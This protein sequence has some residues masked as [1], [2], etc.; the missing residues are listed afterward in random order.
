MSQET[1]VWGPA[2]NEYRFGDS[3][4]DVN[5]NLP[6]SFGTVEWN[7]L[8]VA[9]EYKENEVRYFC[10]PLHDFPDPT[11]FVPPNTYV[12]SS[13]YA[14]FLFTN[15]KL[16][17]TSIRLIHDDQARNYKNVT[18][19]YAHAVN[20]PV[21]SDGTFH[22]EDERIFYYSSFQSDHTVI[23]TILKGCVKPDG[24]FWNPYPMENTSQTT[25]NSLP[26]SSSYDVMISYCHHD[27]DLCHKLYERLVQDGYRVW[28]DLENMY[29]ETVTRMAEGIENSKFVL[30]CMSEKY[31][32]SSSCQLEAE[33]AFK[34][35]R[36]LIPLIFQKGYKPTG[37]LGMLA[38]LRM[39]VDFTKYNFDTAYEKLITEIERYR[40]QK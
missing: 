2:Y 26:S 4:S 21:F 38:G 34:T 22:Y 3:P 35:Q 11:K 32:S 33:Y 16:F 23:E 28:I 37:W 9:I 8:P 6:V 7:I 36:C 40:K 15:G 19:A 13:S 30:I 17:R 29:G 18:E 25:S 12:S 1:T 39:Y 20:T 14:C 27:K 24:N 10:V 5:K 31:K